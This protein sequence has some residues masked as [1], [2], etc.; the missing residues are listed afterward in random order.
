MSLTN[1][2][3]IL[4]VASLPMMVWTMAAKVIEMHEQGETKVRIILLLQWVELI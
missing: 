1:R 4:N 2:C 3:S